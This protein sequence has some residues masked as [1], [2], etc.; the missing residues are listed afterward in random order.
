MG[1]NS[2]IL[3]GSNQAAAATMSAD[4]PRIITT[5]KVTRLKTRNQLRTDNW[6]SVEDD[7]FI[8]GLHLTEMSLCDWTVA[9]DEVEHEMGIRGEE[10]PNIGRL[11]WTVSSGHSWC[12]FSLRQST[13]ITGVL[14]SPGCP[15]LVHVTP[16]ED[17]IK[18]RK[19]R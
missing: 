8:S 5:D 3:P 16:K 10:E 6:V 7:Y 1:I 15:L 12:V 18:G 4:L 2:P 11:S 19:E 14:F 13:I 9:E 17:R